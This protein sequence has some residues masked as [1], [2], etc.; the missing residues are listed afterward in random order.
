[1]KRSLASMGSHDLVTE[2]QQNTMKGHVI[3][4]ITDYWQIRKQ[5]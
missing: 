5:A 4:I 1:M 3:P 2:Q